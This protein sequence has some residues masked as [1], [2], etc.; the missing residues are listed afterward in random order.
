[1]GV[2]YT[3]IVI[4]NP[5][6]PIPIIKA[7]TL[8][9][10]SGDNCLLRP[11]DYPDHSFTKLQLFL[12]TTTQSELRL[13][14]FVVLLFRVEGLGFRA[15]NPKP[16]TPQKSRRKN[17]RA[18]PAR[19]LGNVSSQRK[20]LHQGPRPKPSNPKARNTKN[21]ETLTAS[22]LNSPNPETKRQKPKPKTP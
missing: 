20:A 5:Q 21:P 22:P 16:S 8:T 6:N 12:R 13:R 7:P 1:M 19:S 18:N 17:L 14:A 4:S 15:S 3:R 9:I 2:S 11:L 10:T